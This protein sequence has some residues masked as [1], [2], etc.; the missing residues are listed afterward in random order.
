MEAKIKELIYLGESYKY[1]VKTA[2]G[3]EILIKRQIN[4]ID[5]QNF[6][7]GDAV[8]ITWEAAHSTVL[9]A[10]GVDE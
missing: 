10:N 5:E 2:S 1:I 6:E 8:Y 9:L 4:N 7:I 3:E